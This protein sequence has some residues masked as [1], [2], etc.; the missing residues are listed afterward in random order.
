MCLL[1]SLIV[2]P[3]RWRYIGYSFSSSSSVRHEILIWSLLRLFW[4]AWQNSR[5]SSVALTSNAN[6]FE[7]KSAGWNTQHRA[8]IQRQDWSVSTQKKKDDNDTFAIQ[9]HFRISTIIMWRTRQTKLR[10]CNLKHGRKLIKIYYQKNWS[11]D[12]W[13][14]TTRHLAIIYGKDLFS[15]TRTH[16]HTGWLKWQSGSFVS[17][18]INEECVTCR[19]L[20]L[21]LRHTTD[22]L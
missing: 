5:C 22:S 6:G 13:M 21:R 2:R 18:I 11:E 1:I 4:S 10:T 12:V 17:M 8:N 7:I 3:H 9:K 19:H 16:S 14:K 15:A 20:A